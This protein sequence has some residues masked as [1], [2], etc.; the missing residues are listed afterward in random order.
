MADLLQVKGLKA[1]YKTEMY[2]ISRTVKAVDDITMTLKKNE[3]YGI[4][5]ESS[6]GKTT[7]IKVLSGTIKNPLKVYEGSVDYQFKTGNKNILTLP[8][9]ELQRDIRW[10]EIAYVMQGSMSVLNPVRKIVKTFEDIIATHEGIPNRKE[11]KER[12]SE[13]VKKLGLPPDV[14]KSYPHELSGGMRQRVAIA[15]ATVFHPSLIIADEPTT[16]LDVV[17]QRGVLQLLREIQSESKNTVLFVTHDMAVHANVADR[18]GIMYAGRL[19]EEGPSDVIFRRSLHPYTQHLV[20]SLPVIGDKT[21]K[22]SLDGTPPNLANPP[23]GCRFHPRCK[24][25]MDICKTKVPA[26]CNLGGEHRAACHL[27][28]GEAEGGK[29]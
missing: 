25:A 10:K 14:L 7:L 18:V 27:L 3:I 21:G 9:D 11:F 28:Q 20:S 17:V 22:G 23:E 8:D 1:Y 6:C 2:G 29:Q 24:K 4:A 5:G 12:I 26:M 16:A 13:H 15:L 19:V